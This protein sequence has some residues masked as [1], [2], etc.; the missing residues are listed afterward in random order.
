MKSPLLAS[1]AYLM[2]LTI[3]LTSGIV[4]SLAVNITEV[5]GKL[6]STFYSRFCLLTSTYT[7]YFN[8]AKIG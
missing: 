2:Y 3:I 4:S 6:L 5:N 7:F 1:Y 8:F